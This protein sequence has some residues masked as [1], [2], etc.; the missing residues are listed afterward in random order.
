MVLDYSK[1][2][3]DLN[4]FQLYSLI[5]HFFTPLSITSVMARP[6]AASMPG[7]E[8]DKEILVD[9]TME[10][11]RLPRQV[12]EREKER[13]RQR[14]RQ[15][16]KSEFNCGTITIGGVG[17]DGTFRSILFCQLSPHFFRHSRIISRPTIGQLQLDS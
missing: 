17:G 12:R 3:F 11:K 5:T 8:K 4:S 16:K 1:F 14:K 13:K 2:N 6:V 7:L 10:V 15:K 9:C